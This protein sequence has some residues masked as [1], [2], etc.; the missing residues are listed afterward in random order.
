[1]ITIIYQDKELCF[2]ESVKGID[3]AM[4]LGLTASD[5]GLVI[6]VNDKIQ[7][8]S[9]TLND[10]DYVTF[11]NF[12]DKKGKEVFWHTSA[13]VMAQAVL[14]LWPDAQ[15]TIGPVI[16]GGF[17]YDFANL[18]LSEDDFPRIEAEVK[19]IVDEGYKLERVVFKDKAEALKTFK[20]NPYKKEIIEAFPEEGEITGYRQG[21][22]FDLCRGPHL[23]TVAKI[24]AFK[25]MKT[26]AAYWRGDPK[27]A[28]LT[29]LYGVSFPASRKL[30]EYLEVLEEARKRDHRVLGA[31][32]DLFSFKEEAPGMPFLHPKGMRIWNRLLDYWRSLHDAAGYT[33]IKTPQIL[34]RHL[35]EQSGH[36]QNYKQN[37]YTLEIENEEYAIKPMNCPGCMLFY[38]THSHSYR[39]FPLKISE[40]GHVHRQE[41]SG[42]L[43]GLMRVRSFHQDDAHLFVLP[44]Q[45]EEEMI[46]VLRLVEDIYGV[47]GLEYHFELSTKP[48]KD[49][50]GDD[51]L[52][53]E[54]TAALKS[55]LEK[56][57]TPFNISPGEG[58]FYGPKIDIH[59]KDAIGRVWQCGTV[60]LDM[61]LPDLFH[62]EYTNSDGQKKVPVMIHRALLGSLER[63]LGIITEHFYGKFPLWISPEQIRLISVADRHQEYLQKAE[64]LLKNE[65]FLVTSDFSN[66][67][68]NKKIRNAQLTKVNYMLVAG[69]KEID[70]STFSV[71]TRNNHVLGG[72]TLME[73]IEILNQERSSFSQ[74]SLFEKESG[75]NENH[76]S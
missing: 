54:A 48:D 40:I 17:Y 15:P 34:K 2:E 52:W 4:K 10:G 19:K 43:S 32:L 8:L 72:K 56:H 68:V 6:I 45:I 29:R 11:P 50:V 12:E 53:E 14:H 9:I 71:R 28:S 5:Q 59:V 7:D 73:F 58:A 41:A 31:A 62:L 74:I 76:S 75:D 36:W 33:E 44:D 63:F 49:T 61:C 22:F 13:H 20:D 16:E 42:A 47:L 26:S 35:W 66:E 1:M 60:Q 21:H 69:D 67:S 55:A 25:L 30:K 46:S 37:M 3:V 64:E 39:E 38:Q 27:K 18:K 51:A 57:G 24:K 23:P 70:S 65:G